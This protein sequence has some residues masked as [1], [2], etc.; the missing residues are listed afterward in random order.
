M[1]PGAVPV[2]RP[3][4]SWP[5]PLAPADA[6]A[7][8]VRFGGVHLAHRP[9]GSPVVRWVEHRPAEGGRGVLC[10]WDPVGGTRDEGPPGSSARSL[11]HEYGGGASWCGPD[12]TRFWVDA[13]TQAVI[14]LEDGVGRPVTPG[15]GPS[16][17]HAAGVVTP[18]GR[19]IICEREL[20][21]GAAGA[22]ALEPVNELAVL[23]TAG[24]VGRTLVGAGDFTAAPALS[25]DG[26]LVAWLRWGHPDMPWDAAELWAAEVRTGPS[27]WPEVAGARRV[28]GGRDDRRS[29]QLGR[30]V[31]VCLPTW[32]PDGRLWWC[33]DAT[34]WWHL[35]RAPAPGLPAEGAGDTATPVLPGRG[36]EV[37]EPRWTAGGARYGVL[38]DGR[39]LF[40]A[41]SGGLDDVWVADPATG[42]CE[43]WDTPRFG[44]VEHVAVDG[45]RAALVAG[46]PT[47]PTSVWLLDLSRGEAVEL[48]GATAPLPAAEVSVPEPVSFPTGDGAVAH[49]LFYPPRSTTSVAP[50]G[51]RPPLLVRIHGGPTAAARAELST[52]VQFWTSRGIAVLEVN[53]RGSTGYGRRYRDLLRGAWGVADVEDCRAGARYLAE[54]GRID[55][56]RRVIRGGSAGG[57]TALAALCRDGAAPPAERVFAAACSLYGV[58]DLAALASGTHKFES[59]YLDGLVGALPDAAGTYRERSPLTHADRLAAPV[60]LLQGAEDPIVPLGQA[61]VLRDALRARGVPHALV[62]FE[63]EAHGFRRAGTIVRALELELAFYGRVLGF[64]PADDLPAVPLES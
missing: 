43:R 64:E 59:H 37:G 21:G 11:V 30:P 28:A 15:D 63:G 54:L 4:G 52:S 23:A 31:A 25:V 50:P 39:V 18:D 34:D 24:G 58:T 48:R 5:S 14:A 22:D 36:E 46:S 16:V 2:E 13:R 51:E 9:D 57:F 53:Y 61:E 12:G 60:L 42:R 17:R 1:A 62:V 29:R 45:D 19:W 33:D 6:A 3:Y 20:H 7:A 40:A 44:H 47:L 41:S 32:G 55:A 27:G 8:G 56:R 35:H 38:V 26:T 10:R 49:G